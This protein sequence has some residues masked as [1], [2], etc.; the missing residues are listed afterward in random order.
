[1]KI[2]TNG[3]SIAANAWFYPRL[4][5][6]DE[7]D[8]AFNKYEKNVSAINKKTQAITDKICS[9]QH[10]AEADMMMFLMNPGAYIV[11]AT[12]EKV[13]NITPKHVDNFFD[14]TGISQVPLVGSILRGTTKL[15]VGAGQFATV[16]SARLV[17]G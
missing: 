12:R 6:K 16:S 11:G 15:A 5:T 3:L 8:A 7:W 4:R 13:G 2:V 10:C 1:M 17:M 9:G 14:E